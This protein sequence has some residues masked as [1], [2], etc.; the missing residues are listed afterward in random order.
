M[1]PLIPTH[2]PTLGPEELSAVAGVFDS[3]WLGQGAMTQAFEDALRATLSVP[4]VVAVSSGTAALHLALEALD[5]PPSSGVLVP[6][7]TFVATVQAILAARLR[8]V[9]CEV[10][11]D[12]LQLDVE[13]C[14]ARL[15]ADIGGAIRVVVPV[16]F[17]GHCCDMAALG[18]LAADADLAIVED[19]AHAFGSQ[20]NG[21]PLGTV[22]TA[23]CFSFDPIKNITC[24]EGGAV[25][26]RSASLAARLRVART[27]GIASDGWSR[28]T[29]EAA[30]AYRVHS[31]GWRCHLPDVNAAIGLVQLS[32]LP[33]FRARRQAI[34][35]Q[36]H[37]ALGAL[38]AL[39]PV[40]RPAADECPF[41]Y[42]IRVH[43]GRRDALMAHLRT[44]GIASAVEY[45]PNH[46]QPAFAAFATPLPTT[47]HLFGQILSLPLYPDLTDDEIA[48]IVAAV[49]AFVHHGGARG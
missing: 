16:H 11:A 13:D 24:G 5:L 31:H 22:G 40:T 20:R 6:S 32:R 15:T 3:R 49:G 30:W 17:A 41:T 23:G 48:R 19:A 18:Q 45:I 21:Q 37:E 14:R 12:T 7:L 9:F 38:D 28:H 29:G 2:R 39:T 36:Y 26:T 8:P 43:G 4:H 47:E 46:L 34:V 10:D 27:L 35:S 42:T 25:A 33:E 44:L 1:R